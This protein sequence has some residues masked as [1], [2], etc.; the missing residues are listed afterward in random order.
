MKS[1]RRRV[2]SRS[3]VKIEEPQVPRL[4]DEQALSRY[5]DWIEQQNREMEGLLRDCDLY[6]GILQL[7]PSDDEH[8]ASVR[9]LR[10]RIAAELRKE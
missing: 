8:A 6:L 5:C 1:W 3:S 7:V 10:K 9:D 4:T 2:F